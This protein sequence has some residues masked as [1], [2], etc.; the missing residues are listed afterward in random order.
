VDGFAGPIK[1]CR[2]GEAWRPGLLANFPNI[3][4]DFDCGLQRAGPHSPKN[5]GFRNL[6]RLVLRKGIGRRIARPRELRM[7]NLF[8]RDDTFFGVCQAL[9]EDLGFSP[10]YLRIGLALG[11]FWSPMLMIGLYAGAAVVVLLS[12]LLVPEPRPVAVAA[13]AGATEAVTAEP[14][15]AAIPLAA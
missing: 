13:Q 9:G 2:A 12:R 15:P 10:N 8:T 14:E 3:W 4:P 1:P 6:A 11:I 5:R 7:S